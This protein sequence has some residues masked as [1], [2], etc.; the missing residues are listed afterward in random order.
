[1]TKPRRKPRKCRNCGKSLRT[2]KTGRWFFCDDVCMA[3]Y[4]EQHEPDVDPAGLLKMRPTDEDNLGVS[5][6]DLRK[7][8]L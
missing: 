1:M 5:M 6:A 7:E 4:A 8:G 2:S 3:Q